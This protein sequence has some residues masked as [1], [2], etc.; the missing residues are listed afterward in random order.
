MEISKIAITNVS[1]NTQYLNIKYLIIATA[2]Q[3]TC[4]YMK[5]IPKEICL[6][7][8]VNNT[9]VSHISEKRC[10]LNVSNFSCNSCERRAGKPVRA[11]VE[12]KYE[13]LIEQTSDVDM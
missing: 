2:S 10:V 1:F 3:N 11:A 6:T 8:V 4:L 9:L 7:C 13:S 5:N 12:L